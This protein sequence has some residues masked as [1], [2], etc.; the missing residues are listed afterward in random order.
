MVE[1]T[2]KNNNIETFD[3]LTDQPSKLILDFYASENPSDSTEKA[4]PKKQSTGGK[5][6]Q[7]VNLGEHCV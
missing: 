4:Q 3:Y 5:H 1:F 6:Q 2:L 7:F